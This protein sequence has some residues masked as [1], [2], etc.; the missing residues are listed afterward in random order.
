MNCMRIDNGSGDFGGEVNGD[1]EDDGDDHDY[2]YDY[3]IISIQVF[4]FQYLLVLSTV[5]CT[6]VNLFILNYSNIN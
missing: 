1:V 4:T 5:R 6:R 3:N 2:G